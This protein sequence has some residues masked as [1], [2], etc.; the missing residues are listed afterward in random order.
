MKPLPHIYSVRL[1][2]GPEGYAVV[3][4]AVV[5]KV[6]RLTRSLSSERS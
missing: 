4:V 1:T 6:D 2:G 5:Y 3:D